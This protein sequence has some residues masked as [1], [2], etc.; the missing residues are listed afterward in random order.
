MA[1][2][3]DDFD[4]AMGDLPRHY[5]AIGEFVSTFARIDGMLLFLLHEILGTTMY[6]ARALFGGKSTADLTGAIKTLL[7]VNG[8][9]PLVLKGF[10]VL[11]NE[12]DDLRLAR[13]AVAHRMLLVKQE[14]MAFTD[15]FTRK[16]VLK[17]VDADIY[18]IGDLKEFTTYAK[19]LRTRV[20]YFIGHEVLQRETNPD[21]LPSLQERP[22]A[23][24]RKGQSP[25]RKTE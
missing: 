15:A 9:K 19:V 24:K 5:A 14:Q 21:S 10:D 6:V 16:D 20:G 1:D 25:Q 11:A 22:L 23:L 18:S 4:F 8:A 7:V 2:S 12:I 13:N 3:L 17:E